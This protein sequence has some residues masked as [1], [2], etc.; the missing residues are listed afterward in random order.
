LHVDNT[1]AD[2]ERLCNV[3][4]AWVQGQGEIVEDSVDRNVEV[5]K[6]RL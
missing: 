2:V 6:P 4:G 5:L 1:V 3:I